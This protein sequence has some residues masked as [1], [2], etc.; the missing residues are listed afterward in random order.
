[1]GLTTA[2]PI[3]G[4]GAR[5]TVAGRWQ[6]SA[7]KSISPRQEQA[8]LLLLQGNTA[9]RVAKKLGL[10]ERTLDRW[11]L[12][13][14]FCAAREV[15]RQRVFDEAIAKLAC[16]V[17]MAVEQLRD[18]LTGKVKADHVTLRTI[19]LVLREARATEEVSIRQMI[20]ELREEVARRQ[21]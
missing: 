12:D 4:D 11:K 21:A 20:V 18:I 1:M 2:T 10:S 19:E 8:I 6:M 3:D 7:E 15:L 13:P 16:M 5:D 14:A 17:D 9:K